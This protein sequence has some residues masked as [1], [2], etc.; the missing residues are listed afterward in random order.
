MQ[1]LMDWAPQAVAAVA[2]ASLF[3]PLR[4]VITVV[5]TPIIARKLGWSITPD[6]DDPPK[7]LIS[8]V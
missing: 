8:T 6:D 5:F 1:G 2:A 7:D 4:L 3:G